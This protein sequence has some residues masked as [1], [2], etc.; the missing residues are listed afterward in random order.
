MIWSSRY[1]NLG[2]IKYIK[3]IINHFINFVR[4]D[5]LWKVIRFD[6]YISCV[7]LILYP[8]QP[9]HHEG[10]NGL[11]LVR[12]ETWNESFRLMMILV[13]NMLRSHILISRDS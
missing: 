4:T 13:P 10:F 3:Q 1:S 7:H 12:F 8:S 6:H 5:G 9:L 11:R 2:I